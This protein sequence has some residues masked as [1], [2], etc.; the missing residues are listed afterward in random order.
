[1]KIK[2]YLPQKNINV[3]LG[4]VLTT[5]KKVSIGRDKKRYI[6]S[7]V[8][9]F[10]EKKLDEKEKNYLKGFLAYIKAVEPNFLIQLKRKY[11]ERVILDIIKQKK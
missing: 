5:D 7:L 4:L 6:K 1:M 11:G 8:H 3:L 10:I 9:K 2:Q